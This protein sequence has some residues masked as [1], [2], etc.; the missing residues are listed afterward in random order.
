M[1]AG[2]QDSTVIA[3]P[4]PAIPVSV[5]AEHI[6]IVGG[7]NVATRR[8]CGFDPDPSVKHFDVSGDEFLQRQRPDAVWLMGQK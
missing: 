3:R 2:K 6:I 4:S 5:R 1:F 8:I 7:I